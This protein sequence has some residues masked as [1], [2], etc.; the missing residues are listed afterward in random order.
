MVIFVLLVLV[1]VGLAAL[2]YFASS[3]YLH[4]YLFWTVPL[5]AFIYYLA[6]FAT[7]LLILYI[8]SLLIARDKEK[9]YPPS[10]PT[11]WIIRQTAFL[12]LIFMRADFKVT[13]LGKLPDKHTPMVIVHNH[14]SMFDEFIL[15][16]KLPIPL[17]FISKPGNLR[18]PIAGAYMRK[19]G[20]LP[21][22]QDDIVNG[23]KVI[24]NAQAL[25][26]DGVN[27]CIAPEGTRN[28]DFPEKLMLPFH[29]GSFRLAS[30]I[31]APIAVFAIQNSNMIAS[32]FP[33]RTLVYCDCVGYIT[34]AEYE[35]LSSKELAEKCQGLIAARLER[36]SARFYHK[37]KKGEEENKEN[38][39]N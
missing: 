6:A 26:K 38:P 13:G 24:Q 37:R 36:K 21:I 39:R 20:Y 35:G 11:M 33:S 15:A 30:D 25:I 1:A 7:Y 34:P 27:V 10:K 31:K 3:W 19:A 8:F 12:V 4:W 2:T 9:V 22:I 28:K 14:L 29:P 18:I 16:T 5:F 17:V 32:R 23:T